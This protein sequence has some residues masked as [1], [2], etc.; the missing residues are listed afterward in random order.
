MSAEAVGGGLL[1]S[2]LSCHCDHGPLLETMAMGVALLLRDCFNEGIVWMF[3]VEVRLVEGPAGR[4]GSYD[5]PV[6]TTDFGR[7]TSYQEDFRN[8]A[9]VKYRIGKWPV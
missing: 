1:I 6:T 3:E 5:P 7:L 8:Y 4:S 9:K 2:I